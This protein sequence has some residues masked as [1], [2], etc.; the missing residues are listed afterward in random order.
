MNATAQWIFQQGNAAHPDVDLSVKAIAEWLDAQSMDAQ[1]E[2]PADLYLALACAARVPS[3]IAVLEHQFLAALDPHVMRI[4]PSP[5]FVDEVK[6]R[7]RERLLVGAAPRMFAYR[8]RGPLGAW[9]RVAVVRLAIDL[10]RAEAADGARS[11]DA[12]LATH[13]LNPELRLIAAE[14]RPLI[15]AS[16]RAAVAQLTARE[17]N[18]LR[19]HFANGWNFSRIARTYQVHRATVIR[20]VESIRARLLDKLTRDVGSRLNLS[21]DQLRSLAGGLRS[22][23]DANLSQL[24]RDVD[25]A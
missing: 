4:D 18:V 7:L 6:Q 8:G 25:Q 23:I 14:H 21:F 13:V 10:S 19:M 9:L 16:L 3:A 5:T 15:E 24:S 17:R 1:V 12:D 22:Q 20:W 11:A 2:H